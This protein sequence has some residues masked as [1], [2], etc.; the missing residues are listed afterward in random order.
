MSITIACPH[1]GRAETLADTQEGHTVRCKGCDEK[2]VV[3][4]LRRQ[5][6]A[7][8]DEDD[9]PGKRSARAREEDEEGQRPRRRTSPARGE[10]DRPR[11]RRAKRGVPLWAWLAGGGSLLLLIVVVVVV[12]GGRKG[13]P[14]GTGGGN[15]GDL[16][17]GGVLT[18]ENFRKLKRGMSQ[19]EVRAIFG[20]PQ[21]TAGG[22]DLPGWV[23]G[24]MI[25]PTR[26]LGMHFKNGKL[27]S[28]QLSRVTYRDSGN[29]NY[30]EEALGVLNEQGVLSTG[31]D[32]SKLNEA[33]IDR[34]KRGMTE[35]EVL[36]I[37]G[38]PTD[39][40]DWPAQG[41]SAAHKDLVWFNGIWNVAVVIEK[42]R[43]TSAQGQKVQQRER[44]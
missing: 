14:G 41:G 33:N 26:A 31:G 6:S 27:D 12:V 18:L 34:I 13:D 43:V 5:R 10:E 32:S 22:P 8:E 42:G 24:P 1:C 16:S 30:I 20:A 37:L 15:K 38:P 25:R 36:A 44:P 19:A 4:K 9:R 7:N 29:N 3:E 2:F 28:A 40:T 11:R 17:G 35:A 39:R 23:E 21:D